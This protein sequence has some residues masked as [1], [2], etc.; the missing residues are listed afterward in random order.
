M[1][2]IFN[3]QNRLYFFVFAF[4]V[5]C[6]PVVFLPKDTFLFL[7]KEDGPFEWAAAT[8]LF[9][10][11]IMFFILFF[12]KTSFKKTADAEYFD[13]RKKRTFFF[14]LGL[15][16]V[17]LVGEE[18]SWGQRILGIETPEKI[19]ERNMQNELNLHNLDI[20]HLNTNKGGDEIINKTG[21]KAYLTAKK[22]FVYIFLG[23]LFLLPLGV[24]YISFI[25]DL[26]KR[27][28]VPVPNV[29][30]GL[31]FILNII[32]F[33]AFKPFATDFRGHGRGLEEIEEFNFAVILFL[34]PFV[35]ISL[36]KVFKSSRSGK[37][38]EVNENVN[39]V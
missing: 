33:K 25:R 31:M 24:K 30:L 38:Y 18:I 23:F 7:M 34:I 22:L 27:F 32:L 28:Y 10:S 6:Y 29:Q 1:S 20:F 16:F 21:I 39:T 13:T 9:L 11:A 37:D 4:C 3:S 26:A 12:K 17:I 14:L 5:L 19:A 15:F 35:W 2:D 8:L 36:S